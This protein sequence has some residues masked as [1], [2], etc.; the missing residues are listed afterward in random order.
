MSISAA[1]LV[2][3]ID[4]IIQPC[5]A[6]PNRRRID[7]GPLQLIISYQTNSGYSAFDRA[8]GIKAIACLLLNL[9][10]A[11]QLSPHA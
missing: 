1:N 4:V 10:A 7:P 8:V 11:D 6:E 2:N 5:F 3:I 9:T